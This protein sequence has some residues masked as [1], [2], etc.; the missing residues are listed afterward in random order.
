MELVQILLFVRRVQTTRVKLVVPDGVGLCPVADVQ[1]AGVGG[2]AVP[3]HGVAGRG[4]VAGD[5]EAV[6]RLTGVGGAGMARAETPATPR[7]AGGGGTETSRL[8]AHPLRLRLL[9]EGHNG[10][11]ESLTSEC[12]NE[13]LVSA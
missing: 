4:V 8:E 7:A 3:G 9:P 12:A 11:D 1:I 13:F 6:L 2:G 10:D 5:D